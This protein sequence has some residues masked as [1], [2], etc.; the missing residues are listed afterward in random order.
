MVCPL[1]PSGRL[2]V[3]PQPSVSARDAAE[4]SSVIARAAYKV[5]FLCLPYPCHRPL[6]IRSDAPQERGTESLFAPIPVT[7]PCAG[8]SGG[9]D[10]ALRNRSRLHPF[11]A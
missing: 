6:M 2:D 4:I 9:R 5:F 10:S 8:P 1:I 7:G 11:W 3:G